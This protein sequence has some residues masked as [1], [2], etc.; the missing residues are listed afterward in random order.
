MSTLPD[1]TITK[2]MVYKQFDIF[3]RLQRKK[4]ENSQ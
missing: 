4:E 1:E 3:F 2:V